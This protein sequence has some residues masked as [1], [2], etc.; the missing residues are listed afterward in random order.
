MKSRLL[1][2][3]LVLTLLLSMN[4]CKSKESAYKAAYEQAKDR[5]MTSNVEEITPVEKTKPTTAAPVVAQKEKVTPVDYSGI[6]RFSVVIGSFTNR[7]NA[8]SLKE[9]ME[10]KGYKAFLAQNERGMYR[11][12]IATFDEKGDAAHLRDQIKTQYY[13]DQ[14]QDA[15]ILEQQY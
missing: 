14:F 8:T 12:I 1:L 15:W 4:A 11:V 2:M 6:K 7:T 10:A 13:P 5:D 9:N 3:G